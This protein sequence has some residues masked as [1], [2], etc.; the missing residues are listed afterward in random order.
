[1][2]DHS[3]K[4]IVLR[5]LDSPMRGMSLPRDIAL[6]IFLIAALIGLPVE[7]ATNSGPLE[8]MNRATHEFNTTVDGIFLKPVARTYRHITPAFVRTAVRNFFSNIDDVRVVAN[9]VLQLNFIQAASDLSRVVVNTTLG[10]GGVINAADSL[11]GLKKNHED[12]GKTLAHWGVGAGPYV[13]LPF[14]G[15][16][17]V[18]DS[19]GIGFDFLLDPIPAA[20][21]ISSRNSL[22]AGKTVESRAGVLS[23]D[24]LIIGD[25]YLFLRGAYLQHREYVVNE[26]HMSLVFTDFDDF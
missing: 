7:A 24:D 23:F 10:G 19:F 14:F 1:M 17:T 12:F 20:D 8:Q 21:H 25:E 13:V 26:N 5:L 3:V 18:R 9:D 2:V 11:F 6:A 4:T 22:I 16:S 15:P